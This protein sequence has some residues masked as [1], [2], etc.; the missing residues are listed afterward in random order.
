MFIMK[1][2]CKNLFRAFP[3]PSLLHLHRYEQ[4]EMG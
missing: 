2:S 4:N 1:S 3:T